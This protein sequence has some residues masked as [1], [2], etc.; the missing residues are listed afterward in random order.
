MMESSPRTP[1][2]ALA[3]GLLADL[4]R[5]LTQE[6][7]LAKHEMQQELTKL[8]K[9]SIQAG[10][11]V[12]LS[13]MTVILLC[14]MLVYLL[15]SVTGLSLWASYGA[16]ALLAAARAAGLAYR[17]MT[18]GSSL[19]LWPFRTLHTLKEDIQWIKEQVFSAKT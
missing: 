9:A 11:A 2:V 18:L 16:V 13:L 12:V 6:F 15:H 5:L 7:Q 19:R 8:L 3:S 10:V 17:V 14:L 1:I 4:R